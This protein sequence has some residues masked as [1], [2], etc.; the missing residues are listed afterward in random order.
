[1]FLREGFDK[2]VLDCVIQIL[3]CQ[4]WDVRPMFFCNIV[5]V[6]DAFFV[7]QFKPY[8]VVVCCGTYRQ[9]S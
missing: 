1:M 8:L 4:M 6:R 7:I 3:P 2:A 9:P 5:P